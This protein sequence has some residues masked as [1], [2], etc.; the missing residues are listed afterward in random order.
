VY[1]RQIYTYEDVCEVYGDT[2]FRDDE[3]GRF[4]DDKNYKFMVNC[5]VLTV[6]FDYPDI[7]CVVLL[8]PTCSP[9]LYYQ[10]VGRG[11]RISDKKDDCLIL[12]Y[13]E[14]IMRH[15]PIDRVSP[16][17]SGGDGDGTTPMKECPSC[18]EVIFAGYTVCPVC[19]HLFERVEREIAHEVKPSKESIISGET[20]FEILDVTMVRYGVHEKK[21]GD[22]TS[23]TMRVTYTTGFSSHQS[24]WICIEHKG[25]AGDN[26]RKWWEARTN[27]P[28]P[29]SVSEAVAIA[30]NDC[31]CPTLQ[32]KIK[33][34]SGQPYP[35]IVGY[36]L[37]EKPEVEA[38]VGAVWGDGDDGYD[39]GDE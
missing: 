10:M 5:N 30:N 3:I 27:V 21:K 24:E 38:N 20:T 7:D 25:W 26:A 32:I 6:G 37:G 29:N 14:N 33:K 12:D 19:E 13:G 4:K 18:A 39:W 34:V 9:G 2:L 22:D 17:A 23:Y 16:A 8:R 35:S 15:G 1:K 28:C 31:L 11:L 36:D